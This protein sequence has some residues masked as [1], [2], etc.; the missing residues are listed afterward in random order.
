MNLKDFIFEFYEAIGDVDDSFIR[1]YYLSIFDDAYDEVLS[2][3]DMESVLNHI[4]KYDDKGGLGVK[5]SYGFFDTLGCTPRQYI[6]FYLGS[7]KAFLETYSS[8]AHMEKLLRLAVHN[9]LSNV[10]KFGMYG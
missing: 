10:V 6:F 9:P 5:D 7:Y 4:K 8:L 1:E 3:G 2:T